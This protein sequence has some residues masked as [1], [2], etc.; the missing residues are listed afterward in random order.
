M[1]RIDG[2]GGY[3]PLYCVRREEVVAQH[4]DGTASGESAVPGRDEDL[5]TMASEAATNA[6]ARSRHS[7]ADLGVVFSASVTDPYAEHGVAAQVAYRHGATGDV[8]TG[9]LRGSAR[10]AGDAVATARRAV[11]VTGD[12]AL[13]V[14]ADAMPVEPGHDDE[15]YSGAAAGALVL[16]AEDADSGDEHSPAPLAEI[17]G[18]GRETT[19]FV[20]RH[21]EHGEA[22]EHGDGRFEGEVGF[23]GAVPAAA[24]AALGTAPDV[25]SHVVVQAADQRMARGAV[26]EFPGEVEHVSTFDAVGYAGTA[27]FLLDLTQLLET[28]EAGTTA[29]AVSY[30]AGGADAVALSTEREIVGE[31][32]CG[33]G[34]EGER[35]TRDGEED[36]ATTGETGATTVQQYLDSR[37]Y[38]SYAD[39]L[40]YRERPAY[41]GVAAE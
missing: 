33:T 21:R 37:E 18:V 34:D 22:A 9:D 39:H 30:G 31:G 2:A 23:G 28:A 11:Q 27:S 40:R 38:V 41:K 8:R 19:G 3:V 5:V 13:V 10:A 32:E 7:A 36:D 24:Q 17:H 15:P 35:E 29:L 4:G 1:V 12:P 26:A 14:A 6:L 20:E 25:P 16:A